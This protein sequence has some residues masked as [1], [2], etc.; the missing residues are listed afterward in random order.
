MSKDQPRTL[1]TRTSE[2]GKLERKDATT[3]AAVVSAGASV[4]SAGA[5]V[6]SA[7]QS[8]KKPPSKKD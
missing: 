6:Y 4:V 3:V 7:H 1:H 2:P 5:A 8:G